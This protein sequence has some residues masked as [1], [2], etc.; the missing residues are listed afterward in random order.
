MKTCAGAIG[1]AVSSAVD[2]GLVAADMRERE[3]LVVEVEAAEE[4]VEGARVLK[5]A[6]VAERPALLGASFVGKGG[7]V[8][9]GADVVGVAVVA[10]DVCLGDAVG[11]EAVFVACLC[12][13]SAALKVLPARAVVVTKNSVAVLAVEAVVVAGIVVVTI[14]WETDFVRGDVV[15]VTVVEKFEAGVVW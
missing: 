5:T 15:F 7:E 4:E 12:V 2:V 10:A 6:D 11:R 8:T 3:D 14:D 13:G 1:V 9:L